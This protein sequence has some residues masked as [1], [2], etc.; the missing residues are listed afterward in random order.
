[1][2]ETKSLC[3]DSV[4]S[5]KNKW[6]R[7]NKRR[8]PRVPSDQDLLFYEG[9]TSSLFWDTLGGLREEETV[10]WSSWSIDSGRRSD[11]TYGLYSL[12]ILQQYISL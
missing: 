1:M 2:R 7:V 12:F 8:I 11:E 3:T 5:T 6:F 10:L 4:S 9:P